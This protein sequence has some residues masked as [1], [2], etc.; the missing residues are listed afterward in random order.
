[1][2]PPDFWLV[3]APILPMA[4]TESGAM[5]GGTPHCVLG[6]SL[7]SRQWRM[8]RHEF[9]RL[10]FSGL[11]DMLLAGLVQDHFTSHDKMGAWTSPPSSH[12]R[13]CKKHQECGRMSTAQ[14][15]QALAPPQ[16]PKKC[17]LATF[18]DISNAPAKAPTSVQQN[19]TKSTSECCQGLSL[20][21]LATAASKDDPAV[22]SRLHDGC[23]SVVSSAMRCFSA[24]AEHQLDWPLDPTFL[25]MC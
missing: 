18:E 13:T 10:D 2:A 19:T 24:T 14:K 17:H 12:R 23:S 4:P 22:S 25:W 21:H 7:I 5:C 9:K 8:R 1:M 11:D 16:Q 6:L 15:E 3:P 20:D